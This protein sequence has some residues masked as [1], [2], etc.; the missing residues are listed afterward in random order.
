M[1]IFTKQDYEAFRTLRITHMAQAFE[2]LLAQETNELVEPENLFRQAATDALDLRR[3]NKIERLIKQAGFAFAD[4]AIEQLDYR[5]EREAINPIRIKRYA[6][7]DWGRDPVNLVITGASGS[8]K[9]YLACALGIAA[10]HQEHTV[11]YWRTDQLALE[12][13]LVQDDLI[14]QK[15]LL[16]SLS[17]VDL[18]ILDDFMAVGIDP[19]AVAGMFHLLANRD[20]RLPTMILAQTGPDYWIE[21][22]HDRVTADSIVNRLANNSRRIN[23]GSVDMRR[24]MSLKER[25]GE[26]F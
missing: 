2:A 15:Q 16:N 11:K 22:I 25:Q 6:K 14:A 23:L 9:T 1:N 10:C 19:R 17:D 3:S 8:G 5:T 13:L 12:L 7:N 24:E 21:A 4:A 26:D 20:R 18:L